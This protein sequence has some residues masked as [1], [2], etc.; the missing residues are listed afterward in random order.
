V[1]GMTAQQVYTAMESK[2]IVLGGP[3]RWPEWPN[4]IRVTVGTYEEMGKFNAALTKV[5]SEGPAPSK[6]SAV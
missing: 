1:K 6:A 3:G 4:H 5:L 2:K